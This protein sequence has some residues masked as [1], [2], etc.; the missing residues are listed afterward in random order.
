MSGLG[1]FCRLDLVHGPNLVWG[2]GGGLMPDILTPNAGLANLAAEEQGAELIATTPLLQDLW[3]CEE[4]CRL[5]L[6]CR[7]KVER[8][9][10]GESH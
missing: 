10:T 9:G 5:Y 4:P 7:L 2:E 6:A 1:S 8:H 3:T